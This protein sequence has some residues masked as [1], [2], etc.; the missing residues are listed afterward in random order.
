[1]QFLHS[2]DWQIG[3]KAESVGRTAERVREERLE[4]AKRVVQA[5]RDNGAEMVFLSGDVFE[6]N[7]VDRLLVRKVGEILR[8]FPGPVYIIPGNHD[9]LVPGSV[10]EHSVWKDAANITVLSKS[11]PVELDQCILFPCPLHEKYSTKNPTAWIDAKNV[12]KPAIGLAHGNVEGIPNGEPDYPIPRDAANRLGLDYL[13]LGHWH[14]FARYDTGDGVCR[15]AYAGTHET[16]K[17]GERDSGNVVVVEIAHHGTPP[18]LTP[19]KTGRLDWRT[20]ERTVDQPQSLEAVIE[21]LGRLDPPDATLVRV[22]IGGVLFPEDRHALVRIEELLASRFLFGSLD[23]S[24]LIPAPD[25]EGWI[26]SLASGSFREAAVKL[27]SQ[28]AQSANPA[29]RA[30]ATHALLQL[31]ELYERSRA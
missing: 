20:V 19:V 26:E 29:E 24:A 13:A 7:A 11:E 18:K 17:F 30:V 12:T 5:A 1:M 22:I 6:D 14:S 27:R 4:A 31:F 9:P 2:S 3:M 8:A 25:G 15:M 10:W 21:E 23:T 28:A 16:T